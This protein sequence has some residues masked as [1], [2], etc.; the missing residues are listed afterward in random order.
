MPVLSRLGSCLSLSKKLAYNYLSPGL[1]VFSRNI[2]LESNK[3]SPYT[4]RTAPL[5]DRPKVITKDDKRDFMALFPDIVR[6]IAVDKKELGNLPDFSNLLVK[7]LQYNVSGGKN[8]RGLTV[9]F[10]F[11]MLASD[12]DFTPENIRISQILGWAVEM[13]QGFF[14]VV[15]DVTDS[16][17]SRRGRLC[18]YKLPDVGLRAASDAILLEAEAYNLIRKYCGDKKYYV[19]LL[20]LVLETVRKTAY[21]QVLDSITSF[22]KIKELTMDR[23]NYI[24]KYK[25]SYY[26]CH[27]PV[28]IGMYMAGIDSPELHRQ[29]K[30]VLVEIGRYFQVQDDYLDTFGNVEVTGKVGTDIKDGK[31]TWLAIVAYQRASPSQRLILEECYGKDDDEKVAAVKEVYTQIGLPS[32]YHAYEEETQNLINRQIQQLSAGLPHEL[33]LALLNKLHGRK[34]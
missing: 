23:Y 10:S 16:S 6:E 7:N 33:F 5:S 27:L 22:T 24:S 9:V 11:R 34:N 2:C 14:L 15:D 12:A 4:P 20:D 21:G 1:S 29:A 8:L 18:W 13:I 19:P 32:I 17:T 28:A 26:T 3:N 30:T 31:C 25:T